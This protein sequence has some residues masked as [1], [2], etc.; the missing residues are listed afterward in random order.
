MEKGENKM[1]SENIC[2]YSEVPKPWISNFETNFRRF[3]QVNKWIWDFNF[4][5][6]KTKEKIQDSRLKQHAKV[7]R[8][9]EIIGS[10]TTT[11]RLEKSYF[12]ITMFQFEAYSQNW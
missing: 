8:L 3:E 11:R 7:Q 4:V 12:Y 9:Q 6:G 5:N 10:T 1:F 2:F